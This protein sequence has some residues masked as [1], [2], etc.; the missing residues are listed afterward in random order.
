MTSSILHRIPIQPPIAREAKGIYITLEDGNVFIDACGGALVTAVGHCHPTVIR[1]IEE[2]IGKLTFLWSMSVSNSPAEE[3]AKLL[4]E[5]SD[6]A[7]NAATFYNGGSESVEAAMKVTKQYFFQKNEPQRVKF[8]ARE[9]S[10][11]GD[12]ISTLSLTGGN[13]YTAPF[14]DLYDKEHFHRVSAVYPFRNAA[15]AGGDAAYVASLIRELD[16]KFQELGPDTVC[17]FIAEPIAGAGLGIVKAPDGYFEGVRKICDKYGALLIYDEVLCGQ[18]RLG[19][20]HAWQ[21]LGGKDRAV[22]PDLQTIGKCLG[23]GYAPIAALLFSQKVSDGIK[24]NGNWLRHGHTYS[25]HILSCTA[26]L[27]VQ[28]L[29]KSENLLE[30]VNAIGPYIEKKLKLS[31]KDSDLA[32]FVADIRGG[33]TLWGIEFSLEFVG[34][35]AGFFPIFCYQEN[36]LAVAV[37]GTPPNDDSSFSGIGDYTSIAPPFN[38]SKEEVDMIIEKFS[39]ALRNTLKRLQ[40]L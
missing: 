31:L 22:R 23:G 29:I 7:F 33:G 11:H 36:L 37:P 5:D 34:K 9:R 14:N 19:T 40:L 26:A 32:P 24:I 1:A 13:P 6:G 28:R 16:D 12:T 27:A 2:Q 21:S 4:V 38:V 8:I 20:T 15:K 35:I 30:N 18:G 25:N 10:Y 17:A 39:R 3:L